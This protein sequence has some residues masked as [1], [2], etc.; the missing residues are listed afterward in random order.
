VA[1]RLTARA[2][3]LATALLAIAL[4]AA[5]AF[6]PQASAHAVVEEIRP[7]DSG[8][9]DAGPPEVVVRF[10]EPVQLLRPS[11]L[12]VVDSTGRAVSS[13]PG[14]VRA[15]DASVIEA[16]VRDGL[17]PGTYTTRWRVV[18]ADGHI[19]PGAAVFAVGDVP[20]APPYLGGPGGASGPTETSAWAVTARWV[21]LVGIG[22]LVALL[23]FRL[24]VWG[25]A[26]RPPAPM[27]RAQRDAALAWSRDAWWIGFGALAL[28][29][30]LGEATVLVVKTA[31]SLGT[32][33]WGA[34]GDPAGIVRVL[35]DTR[36]GDLLQVRTLALFVVFALG[37]W[38]FLAEYRSDAAPAPSQADGGWRPMLLMLVP[39]LVAL[40]SISAQGHASTTSLPA[41]QVPMDALHAAMASAWIGGLAIIAVHLLRLPAVAGEGG[42]TAAGLALARFSALALV[43]VAVLVVSGVVRAFGQMTSPAD[44]WESPY[45]WTILVK[46]GLLVVAS[47]LAFRSRRVV[48]ALRRRTGAPNA[49]TLARVRRNAWAE[50]AI[51]LLIVAFS[52]L[53]VGQVPP[54]S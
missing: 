15:A 25:A 34:L 11:D 21:E 19:I 27:P 3:A 13:G 20:M 35:A 48:S 7:A 29:A 50:T 1:V 46:V 45:G 24:L 54:I 40:G 17:P 36:F 30:L 47:I 14:R 4:G 39:A 28:V 44:L 49:A 2:L 12:E 6:A 52:A 9:V 37:V 23:V 10:S 8:R 22:G 43:A 42:R 53:L 32:S 5:L 38:R 31:G 18:S 51:T 16:P 33:V 41:L 26:W